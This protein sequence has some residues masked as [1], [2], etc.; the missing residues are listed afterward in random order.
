MEFL[1]EEMKIDIAGSKY[2]HD[3]EEIQTNENQ[4]LMN[5]IPEKN[6]QKDDADWIAEGMLEGFLKHWEIDEEDQILLV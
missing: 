4:S 6:A 5:K 1:F 3:P 2:E